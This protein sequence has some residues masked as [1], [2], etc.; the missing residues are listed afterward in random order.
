MHML[1]QE[2]NADTECT[3]YWNNQAATSWGKIQA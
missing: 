3:T 1:K 2:L